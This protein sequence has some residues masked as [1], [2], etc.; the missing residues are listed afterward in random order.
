M[1]CRGREQLKIR[2]PQR[3][4]A[5][6]QAASGS[7]P[8]PS[9]SIVR[10]VGVPPRCRGAAY[11]RRPTTLRVMCPAPSCFLRIQPM[12]DAALVPPAFGSGAGQ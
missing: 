7:E 1:A 3:Y 5:P 10:I 6:D 8:L 9:S 2:A 4:P 12:T 11:R